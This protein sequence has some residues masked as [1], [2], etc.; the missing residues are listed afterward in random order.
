MFFTFTFRKITTVT[1]L[2]IC[3]ALTID[4][5][6]GNHFPKPYSCY[7]DVCNANSSA[8]FCDVV[9]RL[10]RPCED[11]KNDCFSRMMTY[12]CT[13]FCYERRYLLDTE[14]LRVSGCM[15]PSAPEH[16]SYDVDTTHVAYQTPLKVTCDKGY[17]LKNEDQYTCSNF[18]VWT[19]CF[20]VC[21]A[22]DNSVVIHVVL[23]VILLIV[24]VMCGVAVIMFRRRCSRKAVLTG[25]QQEQAQTFISN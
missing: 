24:V 25:Q 10:C 8:E 17:S 11:V 3:D 6:S 4:Y 2:I 20:P 16:G 23:T 22:S 14:Q 7:G 15:V 18:S 12:N 5:P 19:G 13:E 21:E 1:C 9:Y